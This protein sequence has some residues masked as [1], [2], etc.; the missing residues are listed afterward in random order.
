MTNI[1]DFPTEKVLTEE[2]TKPCTDCDALPDDPDRPLVYDARVLTLDEQRDV[3]L[4]V[5]F[6]FITIT[7]GAFWILYVYHKMKESSK[8][9]LN[10][11]DK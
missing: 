5:C 10:K 9:K 6:F 3:A 11:Q 7:F 8:L 1:V 4:K 2:T